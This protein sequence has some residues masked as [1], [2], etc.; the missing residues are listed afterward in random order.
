[1]LINS[2]VNV[3]RVKEQVQVKVEAETEAEVGV[4]VIDGQ[5]K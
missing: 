2:K 3:I 5:K 1:M 4:E